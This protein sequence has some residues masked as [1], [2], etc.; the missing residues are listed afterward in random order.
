MK[1]FIR[2]ELLLISLIL[3]GG[4]ATPAR[5]GKMTATI[6]ESTKDNP[7]KSLLNNIG[8]DNVSGGEKTNPFWKSKIGN[9]EFREALEDSL[10][11]AGLLEM[12]PGEGKYS[13]RAQ[14]V[15]ID[16]PFLAFSMTV[17]THVK[18]ILS[19]LR[20]EKEIYSETISAHST[21]KVSDSLYGTKRLQIATECSAR[22]NIAALIEKLLHLNVSQGDV[23]LP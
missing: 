15:G 13:L 1:G 7:T 16:Q 17:T 18:Y 8:V 4:C 10:K 20:S 14:I 22:K 21:A 3:I 2:W 11:S 12:A 9:D 5:I 23:T 19:D 6:L